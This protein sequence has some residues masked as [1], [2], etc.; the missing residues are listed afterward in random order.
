MTF[1]NHPSDDLASFLRESPGFDSLLISLYVSL[2]QAL[3]GT[4]CSGPYV[5]F[6]HKKVRGG[7]LRSHACGNKN[8][9]LHT[10]MGQVGAFASCFGVL[11][12]QS[13]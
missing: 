5:L 11:G 7:N 13:S 2:Q 9:T 10:N 1:I 8:E 6:S 12:Q 4:T 3:E